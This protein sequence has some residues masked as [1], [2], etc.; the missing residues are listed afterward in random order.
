MFSPRQRNG[1]NY[2]SSQSS[3]R[4]SRTQQEVQDEFLSLLPVDYVGMEVHR[5]VD[6]FESIINRFLTHITTATE[7]LEEASMKEEVSNPFYTFKY[8]DSENG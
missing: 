7:D 5:E 8:V 6:N 2:S 4:V 3:P 1:Q